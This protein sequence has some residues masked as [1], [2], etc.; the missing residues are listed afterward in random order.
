M[1]IK[2]KNAYFFYIRQCVDENDSIFISLMKEQSKIGYRAFLEEARQ[3]QNRWKNPITW[4]GVE[5]IWKK[6]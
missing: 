3:P 1:I 4:V 2:K 5:L 6:S